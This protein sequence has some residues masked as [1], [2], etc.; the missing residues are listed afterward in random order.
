MIVAL[1]LQSTLRP[2]DYVR[3]SGLQRCIMHMDAMRVTNMST[4][5]C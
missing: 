4:Q 3:T 5:K 2:L 1:T